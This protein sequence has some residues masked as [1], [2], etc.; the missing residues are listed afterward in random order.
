MSQVNQLTREKQQLQQQLKKS[1]KVADK[2]VVWEKELQLLQ[3]QHHAQAAE[4]IHTKGLLKQARQEVLDL[5]VGGWGV[6]GGQYRREPRNRERLEKMVGRQGRGGQG[7]RRGAD[8]TDCDL[9]LAAFN[10]PP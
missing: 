1:L 5:Q 7:L 6:G 4:L 2:A 9:K 3:G 10:E 8:C